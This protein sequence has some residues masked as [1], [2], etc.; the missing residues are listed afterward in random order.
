[1]RRKKR[2]TVNTLT[3]SRHFATWNLEAFRNSE[4]GKRH[5]QHFS[6]NMTAIEYHGLKT[7]VLC[8][9]VEKLRREYFVNKQKFNSLWFRHVSTSDS[10]SKWRKWAVTS[11]EYLF[12]LLSTPIKFVLS[13]RCAMK[14]ENVN[15]P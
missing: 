5:F 14:R 1:M 11:Y 3:L 10:Q 6:T 4:L 13:V 12:Y 2:K 7:R 8:S 9:D 15:Q